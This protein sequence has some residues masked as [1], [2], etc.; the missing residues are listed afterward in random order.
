MRRRPGNSTNRADHWRE[1]VELFFAT[2]KLIKDNPLP[3]ATFRELSSMSQLHFKFEE[4]SS[5]ADTATDIASMML[6]DSIPLDKILVAPY[7]RAVFDE[8]MIRG[9]LA[10]LS[11]ANVRVSLGAVDQNELDFELDRTEPLFNVA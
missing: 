5:A 10:E 1:V 3:E 4:A 8:A 9:C 6:D 11:A 2:L 7:E